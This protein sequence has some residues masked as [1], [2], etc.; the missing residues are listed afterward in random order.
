MEVDQ[1]GGADDA[2][3][4]NAAMPK[5]P[6]DKAALK[7]PPRSLLTHKLNDFID[8]L[9]AYKAEREAVKAAAASLKLADGAGNA[10][11]V[12]SWS[13]SSSSNG[14]VLKA[15]NTTLLFNNGALKRGRGKEAEA[16]ASPAAKKVQFALNKTRNLT[17]PPAVA[18][19]SPRA[20]TAAKASGNS[21]ANVKTRG[22]K[23]RFVP[24]VNSPINVSNAFAAL[25]E[26]TDTQDEVSDITTAA[27][28]R[29]VKVPLITITDSNRGGI[30]NDLHS[31]NFM[32]EARNSVHNIRLRAADVDNWHGIMAHLAECG[33]RAHSHPI[34]QAGRLCT[35]AKGFINV[36]AATIMDGLKQAKLPALDVRSIGKN[37]EY[38]IFAI[39]FDKSVTSFANLRKNIT[40]FGHSKLSWSI[41][42]RKKNGPTIC[43]KC[44]EFGHGASTCLCKAPNCLLCAGQHFSADCTVSDVPQNVRCVNCVV[45]KFVDANH[46]ATDEA[47]P[48]RLA[49]INSQAARKARQQQQSASIRGAR[50]QLWPALNQQQRS[51]R[52]HS[53][54]A[55]GQERTRS[56]SPSAQRAAIHSSSYADAART[57]AQHRVAGG[58]V[59]A[60]ELPPF[61]MTEIFSL[62]SRM[63]RD[64]QGKSRLEQ[65]A[66]VADLFSQCLG[67]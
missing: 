65:L 44:G 7:P 43:Y 57:H 25:Q 22:K 35:I 53:P 26:E 47:C 20:K 17:V 41:S 40:H 36:N 8:Q 14:E 50:M 6:P 55:N 63:A 5:V 67:K 42:K 15:A 4:G 32:F 37:A 54:Q 13:D 24:F 56:H 60:D 3:A 52:S 21:S 45:R 19:S 18:A 62:I 61:T 49:Y 23:N 58:A 66:M 10:A 38:P 16:D 27:S 34:V 39:D 29:S 11:D 46:Y 59:S 64:L 2:L 51:S 12:L 31:A 33:V 48:V 30:V 28:S 1:I 9:A